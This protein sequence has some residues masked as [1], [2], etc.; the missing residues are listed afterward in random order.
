MFELQGGLCAICGREEMSIKTK[1][2]GKT[3]RLA[4]D[5]MH[6]TKRIRAL[7][8]SKCNVGLGNFNENTG[9]MKKAIAYLEKHGVSN[10]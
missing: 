5:H 2:N 1:K 9:I 4:I 3:R 10:E 6:G 7:L 8:C